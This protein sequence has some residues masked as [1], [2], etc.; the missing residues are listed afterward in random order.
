MFHRYDKNKTISLDKQYVP[1][2][3]LQ[4]A[5]RLDQML[6]QIFQKPFCGIPDDLWLLDSLTELQ[7]KRSGVEN[8]RYPSSVPKLPVTGMT[9]VLKDGQ[10]LGIFTLLEEQAKSFEGVLQLQ[11]TDVIG[12]VENERTERVMEDLG[13]HVPKGSA[14]GEQISEEKMRVTLRRERQE[15]ESLKEVKKTQDSNSSFDFQGM[16]I[17]LGSSLTSRTH[18]CFDFTR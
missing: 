3:D 16:R 13:F 8:F 9:R 2:L 17:Q 1:S 6:L 12:A 7:M 11:V 4:E 15:E 5:E 10:K 14:G 18:P